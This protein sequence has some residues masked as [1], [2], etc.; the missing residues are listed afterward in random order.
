VSSDEQ[1]P[2]P[3]PETREPETRDPHQERREWMV[4]TQLANRDITDSRV[5]DAMRAVPRHEFVPEPLRS[6]AEDDGPLPIGH[7]VTISQPYIVALMTQLAEVEPGDSVLD[8]GSGS[9][10]QAAVLAE[11]GAE[12]YGIEIIEPLATRAAETV[13]RLGYDK[14]EIRHGDGYEGW[15]E[16]A[17]FAAIIVAAA[18]PRV[19]QPLLDQLEVGGKLVLPV[20]APWQAQQLVTYTRTKSGVQRR[21]VIPV[22]FVPMTGEI[23]E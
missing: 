21:E 13:A 8:V 23:A 19:P 20:G 3:E 22:R 4:Q 16:H 12:V 6:R 17:P 18:A 10:Y 1:A 15:P 9:G 11:M 5:L 7:E 14:V 2:R